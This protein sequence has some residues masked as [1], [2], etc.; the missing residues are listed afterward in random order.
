MFSIV[1]KMMK[2]IFGRDGSRSTFDFDENNILEI[3][4]LSNIPEYIDS[5]I[6]ILA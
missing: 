2:R 5:P 6:Q 1:T 3:P 4:E